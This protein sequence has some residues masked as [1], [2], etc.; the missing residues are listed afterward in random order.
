MYIFEATKNIKIRVNSSKATI[1][2][3]KQGY[4]TLNREL[5]Y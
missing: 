4:K 2:K 5:Y 1:K 3:V